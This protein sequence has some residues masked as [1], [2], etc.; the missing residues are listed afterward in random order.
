MTNYIKFGKHFL[1]YLRH[2]GVKTL[3]AALYRQYR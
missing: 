1:Q 2:F 3:T